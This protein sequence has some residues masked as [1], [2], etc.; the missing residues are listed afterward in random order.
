MDATI[1]ACKVRAVGCSNFA[2]EQLQ[3]CIEH[4]RANNLA[5]FEVIQPVYNLAHREI[6]VDLVPLCNKEHVAITAYSPL[7]AGFLTGKY[8]TGSPIAKGSRFDVIPGYT[9]DY[10][11]EKNFRLIS[12]LST[13]SQRTGISMARLAMSWVFSNSD[14]HTVLVGARNTSQIDNA[15][16]SMNGLPDALLNEISGWDLN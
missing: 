5:R 10:F 16:E 1:R 9:D 6:E 14:V 4:A 13:L 8:Q 7:G 2:A 15:L 3:F 12:A 11:T